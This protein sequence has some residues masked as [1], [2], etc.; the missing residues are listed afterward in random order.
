[1]L[2]LGLFGTMG[3]AAGSVATGE[4]PRQTISLDQGWKFHRGS[5]P[6]PGRHGGGDSGFYR[7]EDCSG[8]R[9]LVES[10]RALPCPTTGHRVAARQRG[11]DCDHVRDRNRSQ[12]DNACQKPRSGSNPDHASVGDTGIVYSVPPDKEITHV[13]FFNKP[14]GSLCFLA[15][16][17][18]LQRTHRPSERLG[19]SRH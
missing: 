19:P 10:A 3:M 5:L 15:P 7:P 12:N 11:N 18:P 16:A 17:M 9:T 4:P 13:I 6:L 14:T 8:N 2:C 1:M